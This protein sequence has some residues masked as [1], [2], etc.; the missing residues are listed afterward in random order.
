MSKGH[1]ELDAFFDEI[2]KKRVICF[3]RG[4]GLKGFLFMLFSN[5][6]QER[7]DAVIDNDPYKYG[8]H[9][10]YCC[11][12]AWTY[13]ADYFTGKEMDDCV[14]VITIKSEDAVRDVRKQLSKYV[15]LKNVPVYAYGK[16]YDTWIKEL[17]DNF[18]YPEKIRVTSK[19]QIPKKIHY[20]WFG[21]K[22]IPDD[23]KKWME[24]WRRFCPDYEIIEWNENNYDYTKNQY[25]RQAYEAGVWGFVPDY[26]RLD[27][28][29]EHG[30]IYLDTDVELIRPLDDL[31]YEDAFAGC[32][33]DGRV[34]LGLGFGARPHMP[35]MKELLACY[36][37]L[38]FTPITGK[39]ERVYIQPAPIIQTIYMKNRWNWN[40]TG[41]VSEIEGLRIYPFPILD[42]ARV[43]E[44]ERKKYSYSVHH[45]SGSWLPKN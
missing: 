28:I 43:S 41:R 5:N 13:N 23:Y 32:H 42:G 10:S 44:E 19:Q 38:K 39:E 22:E 21:K 16:L 18:S 31:L 30:G 15:E 3:G 45:Y 34:A 20:C 2:K 36:D 12:N 33:F 7:V 37:D 27:I 26:A 35:I 6:L 11:T 40:Y 14:I 29:Y 25:M 1:Q 24:S 4:G 8:T 17:R 9:I